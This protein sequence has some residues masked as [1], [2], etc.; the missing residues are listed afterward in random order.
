M[1]YNT[2]FWDFDLMIVIDLSS[3]I[4]PKGLRLE[5]YQI[6]ASNP[7]EKVRIEVF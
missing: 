5:P 1:I 4:V 7:L 2:V 6:L 3:S